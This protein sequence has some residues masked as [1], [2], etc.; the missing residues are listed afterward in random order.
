MHTR[1]DENE[2]EFDTADQ[3][4]LNGIPASSPLGKAAREYLAIKN[5]TKEVIEAQREKLGKAHEALTIKMKEAGRDSIT[6]DG[7][8]YER[9]TIEAHD[10][11]KIKKVEK[12]PA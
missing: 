12:L 4:E 1:A 5:E 11:I 3:G 6:V 2:V 10:E 9:Q 8:R 7:Y